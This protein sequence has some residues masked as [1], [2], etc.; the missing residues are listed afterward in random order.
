MPAE[1]SHSFGSGV[2]PF[3]MSMTNSPIFGPNASVVSVIEEEPMKV[4]GKKQEGETKPAL[5]TKI[6]QQ[7]I[8]KIDM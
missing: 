5:D 8:V 3:R 7:Q 4:F 1:H 6:E 2:S